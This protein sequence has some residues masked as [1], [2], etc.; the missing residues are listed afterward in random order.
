MPWLKQGTAKSYIHMMVGVVKAKNEGLKFA[1]FYKPVMTFVSFTVCIQNL[2]IWNCSQINVDYHGHD[3]APK[4][5]TTLNALECQA[6]C[7]NDEMCRFWTYRSTTQQCWV[8][9][10]NITKRSSAGAISGPRSCN[11]L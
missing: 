1:F 7:Q 5:S 11:G 9:R 6:Q 3:I 10:S 8:K 2:D 4:P